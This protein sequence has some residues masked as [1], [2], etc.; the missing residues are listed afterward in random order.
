MSDRAW[1]KHN[2]IWLYNGQP[3]KINL[4]CHKLKLETV[5]KTSTNFSPTNLCLSN[6]PLKALDRSRKI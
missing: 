3:A 6:N 1:G 5:F 2:A 4:G